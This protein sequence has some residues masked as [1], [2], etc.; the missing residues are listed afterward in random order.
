MPDRRMDAGE[1]AHTL[2]ARFLSHHDYRDT[3]AALVRESRTR[4][5]R[6]G[7]A[8]SASHDPATTTDWNDVVE[9]WIASR[10]TQDKLGDKDDEL[11][12]RLER[13]A[14]ESSNRSAA[15][16]VKSVETVVREATNVLNVARGSLPTKTW[17]PTSLAFK[18]DVRRCVFTSSVDR[19]LKLWSH[20]PR[21]RPRRRATL[22]LL[23]THSFES[24]VLSFVQHPEPALKRFVACATME[25]RLSILDLVTRTKPVQLRDHSK[26]RLRLSRDRSTEGSV[27]NSLHLSIST[28]SQSS[29]RTTVASSQRSGTTS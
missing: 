12:Q 15:A 16:E 2:V 7:A 14:L 3:L 24:P 13:L 22:E 10:V 23:E 28:L 19:T 17:D 1:L 25:G 5:P 8:V 4:D 26:V 11:N 9:D 6:L 18:L 29:G 21:R 27:L 20:P